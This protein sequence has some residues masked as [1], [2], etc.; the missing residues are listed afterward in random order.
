M[1]ITLVLL[2]A[3]AFHETAREALMQTAMS[4]A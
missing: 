4:A 2:R 3:S 1:A